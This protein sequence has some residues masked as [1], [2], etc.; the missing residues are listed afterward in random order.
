MAEAGLPLDTLGFREF[1]GRVYTTI[2]P[3]GGKARRPPPKAL[4]P[5]LLRVHPELRRRVAASKTWFGEG[6]P[7]QVIDEWLGGKET[8][9]RDEGRRLIAIDVESLPSPKLADLID[10]TFAYVT[11]AWF[12]HFRLHGAAVW[13]I[14]MLGLELERDHGWNDIEFAALFTGL[15]NASTAPGKAQDAILK[16]IADADGLDALARAELARR[17]PRD[18][19]RGRRRDRRLPRQVGAARRALRGGLP[20]GRRASRVVAAPAAGA[21]PPRAR[22]R[23]CVAATPPSESSSAALGDTDETRARLEAAR[24][25]FPVREGNEQATV[26]LPLAVVRRVGLGAGRR[27]VRNGNLERPE[28]VFDLLV[29]E[30]TALLRSATARSRRSGAASPNP[31]GGTGRGRH[32]HRCP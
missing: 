27:L 29:N 1:D 28:D 16:L 19:E 4:L 12:W 24:R 30:V 32:A 23:P 22:R 17:R 13:E 8:E 7:A 2:V 31:A 21:S 25:A 9:L 20:H 10:E 3:L 26:G 5:I 14:G 15:S 11:D 6:R 18:L